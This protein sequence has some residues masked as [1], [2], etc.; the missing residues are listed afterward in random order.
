M[1]KTILRY[2]FGLEDQ[3]LHEVPDGPLCKWDDVE[4]L[5]QELEDMTA[6][7][8]AA[9][10]L[11]NQNVGMRDLQE[12][13]EEARNVFMGKDKQLIAKLQD[14]LANAHE[15][16]RRCH[17]PPTIAVRAV[18]GIDGREPLLRHRLMLTRIDQHPEGGVEIEV[19]LP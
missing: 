11:M 12:L 17:R 14:E 18:Y 5:L 16:L 6:K 1:R 13:R 3:D 8:I 4:V 15:A 9:V 10:W 19:Q 2:Y 7:A